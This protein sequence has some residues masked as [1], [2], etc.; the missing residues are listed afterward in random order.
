MET[1]ERSGMRVRIVTALVIVIIFVS[2]AG[3]GAGIYRW[4]A[5]AGPSDG[6]PH[7]QGAGLWLPLE[8]LAL[9]PEQ[10]TKVS[11]ILDRYHVEMEAII[12]ESFPRVRGI[13]ER[14][15]QEVRALL[16]PEQRERLDQLQQR[17]P[18]EPTPTWQ[19]RLDDGERQPFGS[20]PRPS[21]PPPLPR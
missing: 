16:T 14:M 9:T 10:D 11:A 1:S 12:R 15:H 2:G 5:S 6:A 21:G 17:A 4:G 13:N 19:K 7:G 8:D 18:M 20:R 3:V